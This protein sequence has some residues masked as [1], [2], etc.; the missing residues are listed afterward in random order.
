MGLPTLAVDFIP[1]GRSLSQRGIVKIAK[2]TVEI[3]DKVPLNLE[4][5]VWSSREK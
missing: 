1:Y 5:F 3:S 4:K 2:A